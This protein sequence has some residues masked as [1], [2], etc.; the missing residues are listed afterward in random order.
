MVEKKKWRTQ[1]ITPQPNAGILVQLCHASFILSLF[2]LVSMPQCDAFF[3]KKHHQVVALAYA[4]FVVQ[5]KNKN[6]SKQQCVDEG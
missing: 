3:Q 1:K 5:N 2:K 4:V 6:V